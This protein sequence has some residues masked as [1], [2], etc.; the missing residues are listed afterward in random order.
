MLQ[1][2]ARK[3]KR[4]RPPH[5]KELLLLAV[6]RMMFPGVSVAVSGEYVDDVS[7]MCLNS[8]PR[9]SKHQSLLTS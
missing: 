7:P 8:R 5:L 6:E 4:S 9:Y 1:N 3:T 2:I